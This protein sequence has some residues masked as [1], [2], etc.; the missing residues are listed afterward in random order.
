L[1]DLVVL[2]V[3]WVKWRLGTVFLFSTESINLLVW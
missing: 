2:G 3:R 1:F